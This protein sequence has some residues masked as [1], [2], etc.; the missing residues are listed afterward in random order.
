MSK[1]TRTRILLTAVAALLLV[2]MAVGGTLAYLQAESDKVTNTFKPNDVDVELKET[3]GTSYE[4][5]PGV[6]IKKDPKVT[7]TNTVDAYAFVVIDESKW[8][9][10]KLAD[11]VK[12]EIAEG[13]T[14]VESVDNKKV[15]AREV[16]KDDTTKVF[17]VIKND[18]VTVTKFLTEDNMPS[19]N[20]ELS[21]EAYVIQKA[22]FNDAATAWKEVKTRTD[23][24]TQYY[25]VDNTSGT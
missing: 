2:T 20:V 4:L 23:N 17:G 13:W 25:G 1:N 21:F 22:G 10:T 3:T 8:V 15:Y 5:I 16:G 19:A 18:T 11:I 7:V 24:G 6:D 12:Y 14:L 9:D